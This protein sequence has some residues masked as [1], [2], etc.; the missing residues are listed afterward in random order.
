[1]YENLSVPGEN[2]D[3]DAFNLLN[4]VMR[5]DW[6]AAQL[7]SEHQPHGHEGMLATMTAWLSIVLL[8]LDPADCEH[9]LEHLRDVIELDAA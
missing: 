1:M 7:I 3:A 8:G 2:A 5:N 4:A 9:I 6:F